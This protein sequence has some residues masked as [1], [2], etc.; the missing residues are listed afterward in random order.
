MEYKQIIARRRELRLDGY[1]T[2]ADVGFEGDW[3][4]PYQIASRSPDGPVLVAYNW[5]DA[6]S[7]DKYRQVLTRLGY[8]PCITFNKV[9]DEALAM[10][11][12]RR[13]QLY[14]TQ[15][16]HLLPE[17]RSQSIPVRAIDASFDAVTRHELVGRRV[18]TLG[19]AAVNAC[20]RHGIKCTAVMHPSARGLTGKGS[21]RVHAEM[22]AR[23]VAPSKIPRRSRGLSAA[24]LVVDALAAGVILQ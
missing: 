20:R 7:V 2:L 18:I 19:S 9:I 10:S 5:L 1:K 4:S 11:A 3:V 13:D 12:M 14:V 8:L 17:K 24:D 23:H 15:A 16:F 21:R 22:I 6:P